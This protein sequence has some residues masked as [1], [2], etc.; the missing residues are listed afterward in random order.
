VV[1]EEEL[2][3]IYD[4]LCRHIGVPNKADK[5]SD[6]RFNNQ[7]QA[8]SRKIIAVNFDGVIYTVRDGDYLNQYNDATVLLNSPIPNAI[9]WLSAL[10]NDSRFYVTIYSVRAKILGF[11]DALKEW[12]IHNGM[13]QNT[14]NKI[15]VSATRPNAF[16]FID[17]RS[18][19][20]NGKFPRIDDLLTFKAWYE[21]N[22]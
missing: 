3:N 18:W 22:N 17:D 2:G 9:T 15:S 13:D 10:A 21:K 20:F 7:K 14:I 19:K 6:A 12:L 16:L 11:T 1:D 5:I 4:L 8:P